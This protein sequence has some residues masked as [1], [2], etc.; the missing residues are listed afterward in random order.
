MKP[1]VTLQ[2]NETLYIF[3]LHVVQTPVVVGLHT[4]VN[5]INSIWF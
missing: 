4:F 1:V 3:I 2:N 5:V